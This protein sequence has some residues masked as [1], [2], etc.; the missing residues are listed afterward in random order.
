MGLI[1]NAALENS[2]ILRFM[3]Y[4]PLNAPLPVFF[5]FVDASKIKSPF[6]R[7]RIVATKSTNRDSPTLN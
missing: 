7:N 1:Y 3:D 2:L 4:R 6:F 5:P